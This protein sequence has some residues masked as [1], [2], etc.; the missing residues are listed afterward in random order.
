MAA[1]LTKV[2]LKIIEKWIIKYK[3]TLT[4]S[5]TSLFRVEMKVEGIWMWALAN[6]WMIL[7]DSDER[8]AVSNETN[9][10]D[11]FIVIFWPTFKW[12]FSAAVINDK[13]SVAWLTIVFAYFDE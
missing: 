12:T 2:N 4:D 5:V 13:V 9:T 6:G 8:V 3:L 10:D 1:S 11:V 7:F